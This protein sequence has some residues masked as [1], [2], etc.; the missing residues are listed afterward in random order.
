MPKRG[1]RRT[2]GSRGCSRGGSRNLLKT[3]TRGN[4]RKSPSSNTYNRLSSSQYQELMDPD[5]IYIPNGEM[6]E[7]GRNMGRRRY[8]KLAEE[9]AYT[10]SHRYE[11]FASK[12]FRNR[13]IEFIKAKEVYDPNVILHKLT[14]EKK[15]QYGDIIDEEFKS[16][17]LDDSE[18]DS[19]ADD[20]DDEEEEEEEKDGQ[21]M[22]NEN[23]SD[24]SNEEADEQSSELWNDEEEGNS[25]EDWDEE[26]LRKVL[27]KKLVQLQRELDLEQDV[28]IVEKNEKEIV[29]KEDKESD[30]DDSILN[31]D[32][33]NSEQ[34]VNIGKNQSEIQ[35]EDEDGDEEEEQDLDENNDFEDDSD[36]DLDDASIEDIN[37]EEF[38][39][40][41]DVS[42]ISY[43]DENNTYSEKLSRDESLD[44]IPGSKNVD[45]SFSLEEITVKSKPKDLVKNATNNF[46]NYNERTGKDK[47]ESEPEYGFLEEDYEFDVSKIEVSNVRFGIGNQYYVKCAEL[48]GTTVDEFFWFDEED[49][50]D[51]VLANG[52]KEHR[53]A[54]FLSFVTKGMVGGNE[55]ESQEDLD[56]FTID[57]NGLDDDDESDD[58]EDDDEDEDENK[59]SSGQDDYPYD[60]EDGL[61]DLIAYTRN[62]TQGLVPMLD[63]DFSHNI[64]AKSRSTFDD[65]DIDPDLQ[66]SLTRQLKNYN[67]IKREKRKARK[68][69]EVEEA[70]LR[71]DML[72]KYP[73]KILIKEIRAEF[74]ALLKDESRHSMSFPTLDSHGHHTIKNMADCYHMTTDKCGKQGVRHYLKVSKTKST[75]KYFPNYKRVNAIMRG[76]PIFHRIDRKP[77]PKDKKTKTISGR[78]SDSGGRA[79]FKEGDI[80]GAEAPEID[81]NNL[82]R[83]MLERLGWSKGMGL[84]LSGRGINEPIVAKVKMSKTGIK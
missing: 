60:S 14:Q 4:K 23:E 69:R 41:N 59:F 55:S 67:H 46:I 25:Q 80:V 35:C 49:V 1:N 27:D 30:V 43:L 13:P 5:S 28:G 7:V 24:D 70:V 48:T 18:A 29:D 9:A 21:E 84:G 68:D 17:S 83:Q 51:Y 22:E 62:S 82:G 53:L 54:K 32:K 72:I 61:E 31:A 78:G 76:R 56:A 26:E 45:N 58:D 15:T 81:Q 75:F 36:D 77:N 66:S 11:D 3:R 63:R 52:V 50:I 12:T 65:L 37:G 79:K 44:S 42:S 39:K 10:E 64:P 57:V 74:E 20:D 40:Q 34:F 47:P 6:A 8:G 19:E 71:N 33:E 16:I 2:R 73:E 38:A